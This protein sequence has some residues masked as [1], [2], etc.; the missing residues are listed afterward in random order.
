M[1]PYCTPNGS[2]SIDH[3][4]ADG[5]I[6]GQEQFARNI[7]LIYMTLGFIT[8]PICCFVFSV[9]SRPPL[10]S[11]SCYKIMSYTTILDILNLVNGALIAGFFSVQNIHHCNSGVWVSYVLEYIMVVWLMYC[12]AS[13]IL[14][15]N[16]MLEFA[17]KNLANFLFEGKRVYFWL[18]VDIAYTVV[19][20]LIVP[21]KFY[22]Y[23]PYGGYVAMNRANGK[24]NVFHLF[25]NFFKFGFV[26]VAYALML[27]FMYRRLRTSS[28]SK[29]SSFQIKVSIQTLAIAGLADAVT[30]GYLTIGYA[31]LSP[32]VAAYAGIMGELLW[33]AL[34]GG[35][36]I[37]YSIM[38][39]A[40]NRRIK[41]AFGVGSEISK[42]E[43]T[44]SDVSKL[45]TRIATSKISAIPT[46][47]S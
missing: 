14:A 46:T 6:Q 21:E 29:I 27:F 11:H 24:P 25:N 13:E 37:I 26:T 10:I 23:N 8:I 36:G 9:I 35:T 43:A 22:F 20:T 5:G 40:V 38:N 45:P 1:L 41:A 18:G 19:G 17:N 32:Q 28:T 2:L 16:R 42:G 7:G 47:S 3:T 33:I 34:H 15:L 4:G 44:H 39:G 30:L 12:C 31:P